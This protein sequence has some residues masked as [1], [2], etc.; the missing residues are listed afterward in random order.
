MSCRLVDAAVPPLDKRPRLAPQPPLSRRHASAWQSGWPGRV[1]ADIPPIMSQVLCML[2]YGPVKS[3]R[4]VP[5]QVESATGLAAFQ[6][7]GEP[8]AKVVGV[9]GIAPPRLSWFEHVRSAVRGEPH[10]DEMVAQ[11]GF[12]PTN[13]R[14]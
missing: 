8:G 4:A 6:W 2:S 1:L 7:W 10:A 14:V 11:V 12:A 13:Q 5:Q 9:K 3:F